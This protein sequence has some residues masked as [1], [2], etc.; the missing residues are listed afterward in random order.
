VHSL[1]HM[2]N[3]LPSTSPCLTEAG[4][5]FR[6][7]PASGR[8]QNAAKYRRIALIAL[9]RSDPPRSTSRF[10]FTRRLCQAHVDLL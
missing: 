6:P 4:Y 2:I 8:R 10:F 3:S 7:R 9:I 5:S 1:R